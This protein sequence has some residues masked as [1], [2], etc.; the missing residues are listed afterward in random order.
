MHEN[1]IIGIHLRLIGSDARIA[2]FSSLFNK[3]LA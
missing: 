2:D 1:D 3:D